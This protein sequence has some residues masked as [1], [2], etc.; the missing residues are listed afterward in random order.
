MNI[1]KGYVYFSLMK[2]CYQH[3]SFSANKEKYKYMSD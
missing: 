1:L 3:V 2:Y